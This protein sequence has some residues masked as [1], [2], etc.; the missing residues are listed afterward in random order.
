[1]EN[2]FL[3]VAALFRRDVKERMLFDYRSTKTFLGIA[4]LLFGLMSLVIG[5]RRQGAEALARTHR[6]DLCRF[7]DR[8]VEGC[9]RAALAGETGFIASSLRQSLSEYPSIVEPQA[10]TAPFHRDPEKLLGGCMIVLKSP[11]EGERGVLYMYYSYV[12]PLLLKYFDIDSIR[13]K[14]DLV[15]E[16]SWSGYC[17]LNILCLSVLERPVFVGSIEPRDTAFL[18]AMHANFVPVH[19][20]GNTWVDADVFRPLQGVEKDID[21]VCIASWAWYKR[22]W[23]IF[24]TLRVIRN[25]GL[26]LRVALVGYA[27]DLTL[28]DIRQ[29]ARFF[30]VEDM[31]EFHERLAPEQVNAMLNRSKV[32][33]LWSRREGVN[34]AI[35]EGMAA[36]VPCVVRT[37]FNYGYR[38]PYINDKTGAFASENDLPDVLLR[39]IADHG[40]YSPRAYVLSEMIPEASAARLNAVIKASAEQAGERWT[41]DIAV[42]V[43]TLDGLG[44]RNASDVH[45]FVDDYRFLRYCLLPKT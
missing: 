5:R 30:G 27:I 34:R 12:Y 6:A 19:F 32:N 13:E 43:S 22:H 44:Y 24:R 39:M 14:Y 1:M 26:R 42:K 28:E 29:Q 37:G 17:D 3:R 21:V 9:F 15:I 36:G 18:R 11:S 2:R 20:G 8:F 45:R 31:I 41:R 33:L 40:S 16:P 38:Y 35:I 4:L 25:R 10:S 23:A 7:A